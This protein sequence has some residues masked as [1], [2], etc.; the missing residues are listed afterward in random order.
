MKAIE[1]TGVDYYIQ[2]SDVRLIQKIVR[3][4]AAAP[5]VQVVCINIG[6]AMGTSTLAMLEARPDT[7]VYSI[8]IADC[9]LETEALAQSDIKD[10]QERYIFSKG[11]S[12]EIGATWC[13]RSADFIFVDGGH[14]Y[15]D[16][17][18]DGRIW[19]AVLKPGGYMAFH[20]YGAETPALQGVLPAVDAVTE[21]LGMQFVEHEGKLIVFRKPE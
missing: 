19:Y 13:P 1:R 8:D 14:T 12:Q 21:M 7:I 17:Y 5:G 10:W 16:C 15:Q 9:P 2:V 20:D 18:E 6:A 11:K 3:S 4:I